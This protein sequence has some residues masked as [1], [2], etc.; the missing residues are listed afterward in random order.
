M[1]KAN[2]KTSERPDHANLAY[3]G[4]KKMLFR[5]EILPGEKISYRKL[6]ERL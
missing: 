4:I 5:N 6:A 2:K 1:R 3:Q